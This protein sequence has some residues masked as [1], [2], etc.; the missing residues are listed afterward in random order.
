LA[1]IDKPKK[2]F[3]PRR[4]KDLENL[5]CPWHPNGSHTAG[6]CRNFK[7]YTRKDDKAKGK[8]DDNKKDGEDQG[9]KGFQQSKGIVL[10]IFAGF[11]RSKNKRQDKLTLRDIM[12]AEPDTPK[13]HN[14]SEHPI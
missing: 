3:K 6:E 14:W 1:S 8:E 11:P 4:C 12:A 13:Y 5:P 9:D 10:V 7:N 2:S